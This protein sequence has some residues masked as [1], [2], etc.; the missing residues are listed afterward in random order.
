LE[1]AAIAPDL[2]GF[3]VKVRQKKGDKPAFVAQVQQFV[4]ISIIHP[5]QAPTPN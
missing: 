4:A 1:A 5:A 3:C 2:Q